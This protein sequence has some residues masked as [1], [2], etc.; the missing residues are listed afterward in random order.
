MHNSEF[1]PHSIDVTEKR[2]DKQNLNQTQKN[3]L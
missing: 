1:R 2:P 3:E